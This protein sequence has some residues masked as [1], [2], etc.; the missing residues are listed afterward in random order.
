MSRKKW[1]GLVSCPFHFQPPNNDARTNMI[2]PN[3]TI[4]NP[5]LITSPITIPKNGFYDGKNQTI[6]PAPGYVGPAFSCTNPGFTITNTRIVGAFTAGV[7]VNGAPDVMGSGRPELSNLYIE[8]PGI[9]VD[10]S[11]LTDGFIDA[12]E[13]VQPIGHDNGTWVSLPYGVSA[14]T[15]PAGILQRDGGALTITRTH[16]WGNFLY[17]IALFGSQNLL[18]GNRTENGACGQ[19]LLA[20]WWNTVND[21]YFNVSPYQLAPA[22]KLGHLNQ[23]G[24]LGYIPEMPENDYACKHSNL[25]VHIDNV[26]MPKNLDS[27]KMYSNCAVLCDHE[28]WN[29]ITVT[30]LDKNTG[31]NPFLPGRNGLGTNSVRTVV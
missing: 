29:E 4:P 15:K 10:W 22:V 7:V 9:G 17:G 19:L 25:K 23:T 31:I 20:N 18:Y 8:V 14:T 26:T 21:H 2:S 12:L 30:M 24:L 13:I 6:A 27:L 28:D 5:Q 16:V 1:L 3:F 11:G